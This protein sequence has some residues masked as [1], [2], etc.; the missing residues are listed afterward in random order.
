MQ[1]L[2][3][4]S[5]LPLGCLACI[6]GHPRPHLR[7]RSHWE[8]LPISHPTHEGLGFLPWGSH[9]S[10]GPHKN[11]G[12]VE[13]GPAGPPLPRPTLPGLPCLGAP[14]GQ[15]LVRPTPTRPASS[16]E[17]ES[18]EIGPVNAKV[19]C[20]GPRREAGVTAGEGVSPLTYGDGWAEGAQATSATS[21]SGSGLQSRPSC[22]GALLEG[23]VLYALTWWASH[24]H[25]APA[26]RVS[27]GAS[28]SRKPPGTHSIWGE[29]AHQ[30]DSS[31]LARPRPG[32]A[33][34]STYHLE[35]AEGA[36]GFLWFPAA[37]G[38]GWGGG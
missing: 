34:T 11:P 3:P 2:L 7:C 14:G 21:G 32:P 28:G 12:H 27:L 9:T 13:G 36:S 23:A 4:L 1:E 31:G 22:E 24:P 29:K 25:R 6:S 38:W 37:L 18:R 30:L 10:H 15:G 17:Y 8:A 20:R 19:G 16:L 5:V 26:A 33:H 35:V